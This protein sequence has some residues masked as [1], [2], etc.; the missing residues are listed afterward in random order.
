MKR[1]AL[2]VLLAVAVVAARPANAQ[3]ESD[4]AGW[5]GLTQTPVGAL[6]LIPVEP[7]RS[8]TESRMAWAFRTASWKFEG[9]D[10]RNWTFGGSLAVPAGPKT[11]VTGTIALFKPGGGAGDDRTL[12]FGVDWLRRFWEEKA[13]NSSTSFDASFKA[14]LGYG[15]ANGADLNATSIAAQ[16]P[17]AMRYELA[18]KSAFVLVASPGFG[19]GRISGGGFGGDESGTR[20]L[21]GF[22]ASLLTQSRVGFHLGFQKVL[23]DATP[24]PPWIWGFSFSFIPGVS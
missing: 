19:W 12:M 23:L 11:T 1:R 21:I 6:P 4:V 9:Q 5:F 7:H 18:N 16:I 3:S 15:D 13:A 17:L 20:P 24:A 14:S 22:G 10:D 2:M 8:G